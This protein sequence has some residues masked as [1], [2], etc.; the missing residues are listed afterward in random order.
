MKISTKGRYALEAVL[1]IAV[2]AKS[3]GHENM[4]NI[5][6]RSGISEN[7]LEQL[8]AV[9]RRKGI[10]ESARGA[11]GGYRLARDA[12]SISAGEVIR[13]AEGPLSPVACIDE[14]EC[15]KPCERFEDCATRGMW[16]RMADAI[17]EAA[18]SIS[19]AELAEC[20]EK[21]SWPEAVE[22]FI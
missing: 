22:Y 2:N 14:G 9:L 7:Y 20:H 5:S 12:K 3:G 10:I 21:M 13:A 18:D 6:A 8:F 4:K 15:H 11:M 17:N 19:I 16:K 1:D